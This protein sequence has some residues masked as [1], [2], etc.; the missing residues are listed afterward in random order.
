MAKEK[1][2][3]KLWGE[4]N[5]RVGSDSLTLG[6]HFT[7]QIYNEHLLFTLSRYKFAQRLLERNPKL[8][9]LELGCNEGIGTLMLSS[10]SK[11]VVGVD[12]DERSIGWA[13]KNLS[14]G[15]IE[16][17]CDDFIGKK[18]GKF[19]AVVSIDVIEHIPANLENK[20]LSTIADN[21][22]DNGF[23]VIGTPNKTAEKYAS[24]LSKFGHVNLYDSERLERSFSKIFHNVFLFGLND[25]V[26][27]TGYKPMRHYLMVLGCNKK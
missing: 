3:K 24:A 4:V 2:Y 21:L 5:R 11:R 17:I 20:F 1:E 16:Y 13:R 9:V 27:H 22:S 7:Q 8:N 23:C 25:E 6:P 26:L 18:Y 15:N 12:F 10:V 19:G 14:R